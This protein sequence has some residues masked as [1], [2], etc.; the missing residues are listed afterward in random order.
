MALK[1]ASLFS[2]LISDVAFN[3]MCG[4]WRAEV[5]SYCHWFAGRSML[6]AYKEP[7]G[8]IV[9]ECQELTIS[10]LGT[11]SDILR[12]YSEILMLYWVDSM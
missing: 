3:D 5:S 6:V 9:R 8:N 2:V 1:A 12:L 11:Y 4:S 7:S 10:I